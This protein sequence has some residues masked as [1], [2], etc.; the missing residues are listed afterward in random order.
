[1]TVDVW[2][3]V[4]IQTVSS[5]CLTINSHQRHKN[6]NKKSFIF[7][8]FVDSLSRDAHCAYR[9]NFFRSIS[10]LRLKNVFKLAKIRRKNPQNLIDT[11]YNIRRWADVMPLIGKG[12]A[13]LGVIN[14]FSTSWLW[15]INLIELRIFLTANKR[16]VASV[17][18]FCFYDFFLYVSHP[19]SVFH[20]Q[21]GRWHT[22]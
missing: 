8:W 16:K 22:T 13:L 12:I 9:K 20:W 2:A 15:I 5:F 17:K 11:H 3:I 18:Q 1:M 10:L 19:I 14:T 4:R 7:E 21:N 6:E